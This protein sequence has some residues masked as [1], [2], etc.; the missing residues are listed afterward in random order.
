M[1][2]QCP[3]CGTKVQIYGI[4]RKPLGID[5]KIVCDALRTHP[6]VLDAARELRCSRAYVY[7]TL[8]TA[9]LTVKGVKR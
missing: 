5:V 7:K 1:D 4:G 8:K 6:T 3:S 2:V 9:G